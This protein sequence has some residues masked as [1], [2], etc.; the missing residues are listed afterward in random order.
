MPERPDIL[1]PPVR[2]ADDVHRLALRLEH[3]ELLRGLDDL[4]RSAAEATSLSAPLGNAI[5]AWA[6]GVRG[7]EDRENRLIEDAF[8]LDVGPGD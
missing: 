7:H 2:L 3:A 1:H 5:E 6:E 4:I 8:D